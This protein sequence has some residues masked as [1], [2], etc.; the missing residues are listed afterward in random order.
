MA[1]TLLQTETLPTIHSFLT[2]GAHRVTLT[3]R[4]AC[5]VDSTS[6]TMNVVL[7]TAADENAAPDFRLRAAP[8]PTAGA[9]TLRYGL[10][11]PQRVRL[12]V[13]SLLGARVRSLDLGLL[14]AGEHTTDLSLD[15]ALPAGVYVVRLV[16]ERGTQAIRV[17]WQ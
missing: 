10:A 12:E 6:Q 3:V 13:T 9:T 17:V 4:S 11:Q 5:G 7:G 16:A 15:A 2:P 8:N 1:A 14:P